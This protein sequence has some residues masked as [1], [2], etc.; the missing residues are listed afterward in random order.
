MAASVRLASFL[1][2]IRDNRSFLFQRLLIISVYLFI[3]PVH[4]QVLLLLL[5]L[6][7][8]NIPFNILGDISAVL[9]D[10]LEIVFVWII[11]SFP[12]IWSHSKQGAKSAED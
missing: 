2:I 1:W 5:C 4:I 7:P 3:L 10:W 6:L 12:Y 11:Y 8:L 9:R